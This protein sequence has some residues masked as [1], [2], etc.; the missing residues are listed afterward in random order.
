MTKG[1][2]FTGS[3]DLHVAVLA[4]FQR[5]L[6]LRFNCRRPADWTRCTG[7]CPG[8]AD[9]GKTV[10]DVDADEFSSDVAELVKLGVRVVGGCCGTTPEFIREIKKAL[11]GK[12]YTPQ[13]DLR[14]SLK[15]LNRQY[16]VLS[17]R[18]QHDH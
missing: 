1:T 2:G 9:D 7:C 10:F 3:A 14:K 6:L 17:L 4:V 12:K 8:P 16:L 15:L 11:E 5:K 18:I 13:E